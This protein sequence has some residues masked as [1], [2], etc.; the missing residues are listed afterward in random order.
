[1]ELGERR[2][3]PLFFDMIHSNNA[4]RIRLWIK[5]KGLSD[6]IDTKMITYADLKSAEYLKV[7]P[8]KKVPGLLLEDGKTNL[9]ESRVIMSYLEDRFG[10]EGPSLVLDTPED[11]ARVNLMCCIHDLY[12]ASPNCTQP[13]FAHTQGA[14]YLPPYQ[15]KHAGAERAMDRA[16]RAAKLAEMWKQLSWLEE[17]MT[18]SPYMAGD[19]LTHADLTWYPTCV[20]MEYMLPRVFS[21]PKMFHEQQHFPKLTKWFE[22]L[23]DDPIFAAVHDDV[24][25][26]WVAKDAD[27]QFEP[28]KDEV[29]DPTFKWQY[30]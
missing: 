15:T 18:A 24:W 14:M 7:N 16:T 17:E 2:S 29:K 22:G 25:N 13:N 4:A 26:F 6:R 3:K 23:S 11:R 30:P 19:R 12:I 28:I 10:N 5:L 27:G 20:F 21:W 9:F 1:M 8:L